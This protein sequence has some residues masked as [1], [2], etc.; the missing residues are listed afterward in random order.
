MSRATHK[1][2]GQIMSMLKL[3]LPVD[4][5]VI[6]DRH[7]EIDWQAVA[8]K[9]V[10]SMARKVELADSLAKRSRLTEAAAEAIGRDVKTALRRRYSK[11]AR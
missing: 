11:A 7:P 1:A 5:R 9:A 8:E 4:L 2:E 3:E 10:W 6:L